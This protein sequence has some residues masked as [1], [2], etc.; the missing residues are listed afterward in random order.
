ML[1]SKQGN[2]S[3]LDSV[4]TLCAGVFTLAA[5]Q[6]ADSADND[7]AA[8]GK[9]RWRCHMT[10]PVVLLPQTGNAPIANPPTL[11]KGREQAMGDAEAWLRRLLRHAETDLESD[12]LAVDTR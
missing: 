7:P 2:W 10:L 6:I 9:W 8:R 12:A 1:T 11:Y 4:S 3:C 5:Y